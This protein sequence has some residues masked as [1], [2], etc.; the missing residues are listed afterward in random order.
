MCLVKGAL[1]QD[2]V[3]H[4]WGTLTLT[5]HPGVELLVQV[6]RPVE[7]VPHENVAVLLE[8]VDAVT[9]RRR[10][11]DHQSTIASL[12]AVHRVGQGRLALALSQ[13]DR[14]QRLEPRHDP[15]G[16]AAV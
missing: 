3:A 1:H 12:P 11:T 13:V 7:A 14:A 10:V 9:H 6:Q 16:V 8:A 15:L 2:A 5:A 4:D